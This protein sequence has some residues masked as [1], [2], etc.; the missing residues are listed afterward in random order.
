MSNSA[1]TVLYRLVVTKFTVIKLIQHYVSTV[2]TKRNVPA[3]KTAHF[4]FDMMFLANPQS[5][6]EASNFLANPIN[7]K[8][9][10]LK[11]VRFLYETYY[12]IYFADL[13]LA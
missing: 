9:K 6:F 2:G 12:L 3:D 10:L 8:Y 13:F 1:V 7:L 5:S 11:H 4:I